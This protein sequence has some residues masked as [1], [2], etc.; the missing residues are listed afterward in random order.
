MPYLIFFNA[1]DRTSSLVWKELLRLFKRYGTSIV[2]ARGEQ[3][4]YLKLS[5]YCKLK[6][7]KYV[8]VT[9]GYFDINPKI[10]SDGLKP[11]FMRVP[12]YYME[13]KL[14]KIPISRLVEKGTQ[15]ENKYEVKIKNKKYPSLYW[16]HGPSLIICK[17]DYFLLKEAYRI[18]KRCDKHMNLFCDAKNKL[19][20]FTP[21]F[22][23]YLGG[24]D[25]ACCS[26][27]KI[28][29]LELDSLKKLF[30]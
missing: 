8:D 1:G 14:N 23:K 20:I 6:K 3:D 19:F 11:T 26:F 5:N 12:E 28:G 25:P 9:S 30:F 10:K 21:M 29:L 4:L 16:H 17:K 22:S 13:R 15:S 2:N 27:K 7:V 18:A 24:C